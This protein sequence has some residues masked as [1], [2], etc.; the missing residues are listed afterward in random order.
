MRITTSV[1]SPTL[2]GVLEAVP[3][4]SE[5]RDERVLAA[6]AEACGSA[7]LDVHRDGDRWV[8]A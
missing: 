2:H 3:N 8:V 7:L 5:G 1:R 6:L 4:V